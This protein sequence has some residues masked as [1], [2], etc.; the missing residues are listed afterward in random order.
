M[1]LRSGRRRATPLQHDDDDDRQRA[2][3]L[4]PQLP[5]EQ[6]G[7]AAQASPSAADVIMPAHV[8]SPI[9]AAAAAPAAPTELMSVALRKKL[10]E[11]VPPN[12][13][14]VIDSYIKSNIA[15]GIAPTLDQIAS[16]TFVET[17]GRV[18]MDRARRYV[19]LRFP[20]YNVTRNMPLTSAKRNTI[21]TLFG[22]RLGY[23]MIDLAF[24][25]KTVAGFSHRQ[26]ACLVVYCCAGSNMLLL[27]TIYNNRSAV[28]IQRALE[29]V[30]QRL[31]N[32]YHR[33]EGLKVIYSDREGGLRSNVM[34]QWLTENK[35]KV[36]WMTKAHKAYL[37][38]GAIRKLRVQLKR[39]EIVLGPMW[40]S[41]FNPYNEL[42]RIERAH[43][44]RKLTFGK[45]TSPWS[46]AS[47]TTDSYSDYIQYVFK[48]KPMAYFSLYSIGDGY[49]DYAFNLDDTVFLKNRYMSSKAIDKRSIW[50]I[51][52]NQ[53]YRIASR[54]TVLSGNYKL[55]AY[56]YIQPQFNYLT[57]VTPETLH[58]TLYARGLFVPE[59][60]L[61]A[62]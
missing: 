55:V 29:A 62:E 3:P 48:L 30:H 16:F 50:T 11:L 37:A 32:H 8:D 9:N 60:A 46:P 20:E 23:Y 41:N 19:R 36:V 6:D 57:D 61:T 51:N 27:E 33:R 22:S 56:Y 18:P 45:T 21:R 52:A 4:P 24:L 53:P 13:F 25:R 26:N 54:Y 14:K 10:E 2:L 31:I 59:G 28:S 49:I 1:L 47:I 15:L 17:G 35:I 58:E 7:T 38:E 5:E 39:Q 44:N 42:P 34:Q 43:N 12:Y 40:S